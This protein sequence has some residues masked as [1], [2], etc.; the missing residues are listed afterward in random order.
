[1]VSFPD[2]C[3]ALTVKDTLLSDKIHKTCQ[4]CIINSKQMTFFLTHAIYE[5][6]IKRLKPSLRVSV[7]A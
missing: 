1:M 7:F 6:P 4:A 2:A 5:Q 3:H